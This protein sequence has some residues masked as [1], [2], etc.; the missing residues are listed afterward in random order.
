MRASSFIPAVLENCEPMTLARSCLKRRQESL[1]GSTDC[2]FL[3]F[4]QLWFMFDAF[5]F[6]G[7]LHAERGVSHV[8]NFLSSTLSQKT[9]TAL[10]LKGKYYENK[11]TYYFHAVFLI[12]K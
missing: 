1:Q 8:P 7:Q 6:L 10:I 9:D 2:C 12:K 11:S 3:D 5:F 4:K